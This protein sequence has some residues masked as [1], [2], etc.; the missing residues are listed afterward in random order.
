MEVEAQLRLL[1]DQ[2]M[3]RGD[4]E[5]IVRMASLVIAHL[6]GPIEET[7]SLAGLPGPL[8]VLCE[9]C[10]SRLLLIV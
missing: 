6:G 7:R 2:V 9:H 3:L 4:R 1:H 8:L 5:L 10:V